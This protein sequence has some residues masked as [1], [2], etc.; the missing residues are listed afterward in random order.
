MYKN[1]QDVNDMTIMDKI[2]FLDLGFCNFLRDFSKP[3][4]DIIIAIN[5]KIPIQVEIM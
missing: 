3:I 4:V 5:D 2:V 1:K